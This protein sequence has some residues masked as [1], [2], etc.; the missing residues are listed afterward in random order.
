MLKTIFNKTNNV[1]RHLIAKWMQRNIMRLVIDKPTISFSFDDFPQTAIENGAARLADYKLRGTFYVSMGILNQVK[2]VGKIT[3]I[4]GVEGIIASGHEIGC[5]TLDHKDAW[6]TKPYEYNSAIE[7]NILQFHKH[8]GKSVSFTSF[9]YPKGSVT[10][11][12]K[13]MVQKH[14]VCARGIIP[15][16]MVNSCDTNLLPSIPLISSEH[17][18]NYFKKCIDAVVNSKGWM[19]FFTHDICTKPSAFGCSIEIFEKVIEYTLKKNVNVLPVREAFD[20]FTKLV[21][22]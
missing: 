9:A 14:F 8:F 2:A 21:L 18:L 22:M 1:K 13:K 6:T 10:I 11:Y 15:G 7:Q 16:I 4:E 17:S 19:I 5:H 20:K 12:A 3:G